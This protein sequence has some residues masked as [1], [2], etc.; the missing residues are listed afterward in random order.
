MNCWWHSECTM[1]V[2]IIHVRRCKQLIKWLFKRS[3]RLF[4]IDGHLYAAEFPPHN[5]SIL[6]HLLI[7]T[8][9]CK[10]LFQ[11]KTSLTLVI[12]YCQA[13]LCFHCCLKTIRIWLDLH[14]MLRTLWII[15][16]STWSF[17]ITFVLFIFLRFSRG[18]NSWRPHFNCSASRGRHWHG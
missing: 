7:I 2:S 5:C 9:C 13:D 18:Y 1:H 6:Q 10:V 15:S 3:L 14:V 11:V 16:N 12:F 4:I 17:T 8:H